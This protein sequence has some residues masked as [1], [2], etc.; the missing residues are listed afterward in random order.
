MNQRRSVNPAVLSAEDEEILAYLQRQE[1]SHETHR[2]QIAKCIGRQD[3]PL[4]SGQL[5]LWFQDQIEP[6]NPA[7]HFSFR[8]RFGGPF[9]YD[10]LLS[11]LNELMRRHDVLRARFVMRDLEL[12]QIITPPASIE[13]PFVDFS[14]VDRQTRERRAQEL[15]FHLNQDPFDLSEGPLVRSLLLG[16]D[17]QDHLLM[18]CFHHIVTDRWSMNVFVRELETLYGAYSTGGSSPLEEL[19]VQYTDYAI[20][21]HESQQSDAFRISLKY[22][23]SQLADLTTLALPMDRPRPAIRDFGSAKVTHR[24]PAELVG[25]LRHLAKTQGATM[26]MVYL[27]GVSLMLQRLS[28]QFDIAVGSPVTNRNLPELE[29]L[30][31]YFINTLVL[32]VDLSGEPSVS[33]LLSRVRR[34]LLDAYRH[35]G[36]PF[37][38]LVEKLAPKR[39]LSLSPL[40]QVLFVHLGE[41]STSAR[42]T[43]AR[44]N[45]PELSQPDKVS[46]DFDLEIYITDETDEASVAFHF[47]TDIFDEATIKRIIEYY[48]RVLAA[49]ASDPG[50]R[51]GAISLLGA[52]QCARVLAAGCGPSTTVPAE[53]AHRLF[54]AQARRA[55]GATAVEAA[56]G[57]LSYRE[58]NG[59]SNRL[60]RRLRELGAGPGIVVGVCMDRSVELLVSVLG[61]LKSGAAYVPL[62]AEFPQERLAFMVADA[63]L[64]MVVTRGGLAKKVLPQIEATLLDVDAERAAL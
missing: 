54:E 58:L 20:W 23:Q 33:E 55:P 28:G 24:F 29:A 41:I 37:E 60:A 1:A 42:E 52:E 25:Q 51:I 44:R 46:T 45:R 19:P 56:D 48:E 7:Y 26:F 14:D 30:I 63:E 3:Y 4:S 18:M 62:D 32:R 9:H 36:V 6:G 39:D 35:Q 34:M 57:L 43:K 50:Q 13:L 61:V 31:G 38:T 5:G 27:T 47:R 49:M 53:C 21:E 15:V 40:F 2:Y 16:L 59:R 64:A 11:A 22:W 10:A 12:V 8:L 17:V